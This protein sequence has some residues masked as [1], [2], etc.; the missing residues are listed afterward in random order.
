MVPHRHRGIPS[1]MRPSPESS[2][3]LNDLIG[4]LSSKEFEFFRHSFDVG[5]GTVGQVLYHPGD[6]VETV[7]FPCGPTLL[8][9]AIAANEDRDVEAVLIGREG[10]VGNFADGGGLPAYSRISVKA[11]GPLVRLPVR[12]L[13]DGTR[14]S[15]GLEQLLARYSHYLLAYLG[16]S[17]VCNA[18]HSIEQRAAKW[19]VQIIERTGAEDVPLT[20][21]Q[22]AALLGIGRS[23]AS[24][25]VQRFKGEGILG[26]AR[27]MLRVQD[28]PEL[29]RRSCQCSGWLERHYA[30]LFSN[31][32]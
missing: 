30:E 6:P 27:G 8:S 18:V 15:N 7:Y 32:P 20:H 26:T 29:Q 4:A 1:Q 31:S 3:P 12:N 9:V 23:Y 5:E 24:R 10:A 22:L 14:Q 16:Q 28:L 25:I 2:R 17:A 13:G 11:G 19:I 21:E